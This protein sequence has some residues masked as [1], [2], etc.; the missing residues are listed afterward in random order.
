VVSP[1]QERLRDCQ[2]ERLGRLEVDDQ[3]EL[4]GLLD[5]EIGWLRALEDFVDEDWGASK[6]VP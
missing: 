5:W 4:G 6:Q 2:P 1:Q 3:L